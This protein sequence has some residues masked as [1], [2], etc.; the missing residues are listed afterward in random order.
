M[1]I[2]AHMGGEDNYE[3]TEAHPLSTG[4]SPDTAFVL[5]IMEPSTLERF[6]SRHPKERFLFGTDSLGV[7]DDFGFELVGVDLVAA[8]IDQVLG[9][10]VASKVPVGVPRDHTPSSRANRRGSAT[11]STE[12]FM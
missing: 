8:A 3:D 1:V 9:P 6:F 2:A 5:R 10:A 12:L 4:V 11:S 7:L